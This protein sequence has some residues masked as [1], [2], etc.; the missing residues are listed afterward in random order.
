MK[1]VDYVVATESENLVIDIEQKRKQITDEIVTALIAE[2]KR[3]GLTQ[4]DIADIS[5]MKAPNVTRIESRKYSP[6]LDVLM[7]YADA[8]GKQLYIGLEDALAADT[9]T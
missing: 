4:Q 9:C 3:R 1:Q 8:L 2:R 7:R 6:S 5:G